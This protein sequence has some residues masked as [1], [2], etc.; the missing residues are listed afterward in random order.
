VKTSGTT[1]YTYNERKAQVWWEQIK[2]K[3]E[4]YSNLQVFHLYAEG[5]ENL[6]NR[7]MQLQCNMQDGEI[8]LGD[9]AQVINIHT[10][11]KK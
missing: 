11:R 4:R 2:G 10:D 9:E 8:T 6:L 5:V 7:N 1:I 3:L